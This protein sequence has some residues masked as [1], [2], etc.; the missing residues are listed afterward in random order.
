[1]RHG[2]VFMII[3]HYT[4]LLIFCSKSRCIQKLKRWNSLNCAR[5][6]NTCIKIVPTTAS[7][8]TERCICEPG[9]NHLNSP[10]SIQL[11]ESPCNSPEVTVKTATEKMHCQCKR[12]HNT[13]IYGNSSEV[14]VKA[15]GQQRKCTRG[16]RMHCTQSLFKNMNSKLC[17][18]CSAHSPWSGHPSTCAAAV[19][20]QSTSG[21]LGLLPA[22]QTW[23]Q[24]EEPKHSPASRKGCFV[25]ESQSTK[26]HDSFT[27]KLIDLHAS[28]WN[29]VMY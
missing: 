7:R 1:M 11:H 29:T 20:R 27:L 18:R 10:E 23:D 13:Q 24:R 2:H 28:R 21:F 25:T 8:V 4:L 14:P 6:D 22:G 5:E 12:K 26:A 17:S 9:I 16:N 3:L 15:A 19:Q